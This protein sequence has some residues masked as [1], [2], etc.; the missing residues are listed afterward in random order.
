MVEGSIQDPAQAAHRRRGGVS[1]EN[2]ATPL[3]RL[4]HR[5]ED[6]QLPL[7]PGRSTSGSELEA[8]VSPR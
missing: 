8:V 3:E 7:I 5:M 6:L 1:C 4:D 2:W